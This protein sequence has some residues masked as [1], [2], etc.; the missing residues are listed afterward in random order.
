VDTHDDLP[1][2]VRGAIRA[3]RKIE[4]IKLL[5]E[6]ENID[7]KEAKDRVEAYAAAHSYGIAR[8]PSGSR[9]LSN[10]VIILSAIAAA[11]Y[12]AYRLLA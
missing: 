1:E 10:A 2:A 3:K 4:A 8:R 6:H 11:A 5:R 12:A 9:S 7:L